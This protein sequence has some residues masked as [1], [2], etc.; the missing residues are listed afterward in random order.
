MARAAACS[1]RALKVFGVLLIFFLLFRKTSKV[2][3]RAA[4]VKCTFAKWRSTDR[5]WT[6][7]S[8][9]HARSFES[10]D[11]MSFMMEKKN[12]IKIRKWSKKNKKMRWWSKVVFAGKRLAWLVSSLWPCIYLLAYVDVVEAVDL[13]TFVIYANSSFSVHGRAFWLS[14]SFTKTLVWAVTA[15]GFIKTNAVFFT[16]CNSKRRRVEWG[17]GWAPVISFFSFSFLFPPPI[18]SAFCPKNKIKVSI[19]R[20]G[21]W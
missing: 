11:F 3:T 21:F 13:S 9:G 7:C 1:F 6:L 18:S 20:M 14:P 8:D 5:D 12:I 15:C 10:C 4:A 17:F 19:Y 2:Y 16:I